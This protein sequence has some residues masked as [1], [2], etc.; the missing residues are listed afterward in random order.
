MAADDKKK[1]YKGGQSSNQS[2]LNSI[3]QAGAVPMG[4]YLQYGDINRKDVH[5]GDATLGAYTFT[6]APGTSKGH[7]GRAVKMG[8]GKSVFRFQGKLYKVTNSSGTASQEIQV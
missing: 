3:A 2:Y 5:E 7:Y 4:E 8:H 1:K 6:D